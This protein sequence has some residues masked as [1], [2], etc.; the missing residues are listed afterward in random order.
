[1][2]CDENR[3]A[4]LDAAYLSG[5]A[6]RRCAPDADRVGKMD[7]SALYAAANRHLMA[8]ICG[9]AL[10][11]A[12]VRDSAFVEAKARAIRK[13]ILLDAEREII[14]TKLREE[15]IWHAALK[16]AILKDLY[17][18]T[19]IREMAD[20]DIL[21]DGSRLKDIRRIM[22]SLGYSYD[23]GGLVHEA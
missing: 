14:F 1:M 16:G 22:E 23:H 18:M 6:V 11:S 3:I 21:I 7:L 20:N 4:L 12:G 19:G 15:E 9:A 2:T 5:C 8:A 10:E 13:V 17:P